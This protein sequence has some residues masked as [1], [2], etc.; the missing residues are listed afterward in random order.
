MSRPEAPS[1]YYF[2][3]LSEMKVSSL[4]AYRSLNTVLIWEQLITGPLLSLPSSLLS[5]L[6]HVTCYDHRCSIVPRVAMSSTVGSGL[7]HDNLHFARQFHI[8]N[9]NLTVKKPITEKTKLKFLF[10]YGQIITLI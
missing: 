5:S 2:A 3:R 4:S 7:L 8:S 1:I 9:D 6:G 10:F